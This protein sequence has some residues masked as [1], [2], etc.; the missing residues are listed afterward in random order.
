[1]LNIK[2]H[3]ESI[4]FQHSFTKHLGNTHILDNNSHGFVRTPI[5]RHSKV[6]RRVGRGQRRVLHEFTIVR[7][8]PLSQRRKPMD[9]P[10]KVNGIPPECFCVGAFARCRGGMGGSGASPIRRV[11]RSTYNENASNRL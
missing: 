8:H 10:E 5:G 2:L 1:M 7:G 3:V 4:I 9:K 6:A 11:D